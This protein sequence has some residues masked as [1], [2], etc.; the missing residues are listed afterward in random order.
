[1]RRFRFF[2]RHFAR[3]V[4]FPIAIVSSCAEGLT[5][6]PALADLSFWIYQLVHPQA[7]EYPNSEEFIKDH[8]GILIV[9]LA[10]AVCGILTDYKLEGKN[11][12]QQTLQE[13]AEPESTE[14]P[15]NYLPIADAV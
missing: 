11:Y 13:N 15:S 2:A 3:R 10:I 7:T 9:I 12:V 6:I 1:M 14:Q 5:A 4:A 8:S